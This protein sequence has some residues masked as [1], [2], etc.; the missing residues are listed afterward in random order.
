MV[1]EHSLDDETKFIMM[2]ILWLDKNS[3]LISG[4][5]GEIF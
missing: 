2:N 3:I 4:K 1:N 5:T